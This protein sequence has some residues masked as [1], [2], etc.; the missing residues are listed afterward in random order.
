MITKT[1]YNWLPMPTKPERN[2]MLILSDR[3]YCGPIDLLGPVRLFGR[4]N[5]YITVGPDWMISV[6]QSRGE[7]LEY[8][9]RPRQ[10]PSMVVNPE[11]G[12]LI[13]PF[14]E[15]LVM[16]TCGTLAKLWTL[17]DRTVISVIAKNAF[18]RK[19]VIFQVHFFYNTEIIEVHYKKA[20]T[21][22]QTV[23]GACGEQDDYLEWG[24]NAYEE[25]GGTAIRIDTSIDEIVYG[26]ITDGPNGHW[27]LPTA[28]PSKPK[29]VV[30]ESGMLEVASWQDRGIN[31][32]VKRQE[33]TI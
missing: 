3:S 17:E 30:D 12:Y 6:L 7:N 26:D 2:L 1:T 21:G 18:T 19:L 5:R 22:H 8:R 31:Y 33:I 28:P 32:I 11:D 24:C 13:V 4:D 9:N 20:M 16:R 23:I 25:L 10:L 29:P 14:G 27:D 15:Q